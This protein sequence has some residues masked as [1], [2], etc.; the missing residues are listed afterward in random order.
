M[1]KPTAIGTTDQSYDR[2]C[3]TRLLTIVILFLISIE[4]IMMRIILL[5]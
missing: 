3:H 4:M 2:F 5:R 1:F